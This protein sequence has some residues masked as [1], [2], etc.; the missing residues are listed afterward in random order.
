MRISLNWLADYVQLPPSDELARRLT[1]A[2]LEIEGREA[3]GAGLDQVVVGQVLESGAHPNAEKLSVTRIDAGQG[4]TLQIV[5]G[6]KNYKV[7]DKVPVAL[8]GAKLPGGVEIKQATLRGVD[9]FG[10]LCS[11]RELGLSEDASGLL[12]LDPALKT[13][14]PIADAVP[15]HRYQ[16]NAGFQGTLAKGLV[17]WA[18]IGNAWGKDAYRRAEGVFGLKYSWM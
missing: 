6:A 4:A 16:V 1:L 14:T 8:V 15:D 10:M 2:G 7:G 5:C 3:L 17:I 12:I 11:A 18:R 9:S 13:G